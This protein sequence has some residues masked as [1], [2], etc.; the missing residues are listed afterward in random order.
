M[1]EQRRWLTADQ[2][3]E[4]FALCAFLP[5]GNIVNFCVI[6]GTRT[7][8]PL[9]AVAALGG[10]LGPPMILVM[11]VRNGLRITVLHRMLTG[12]AAAAAELMLATVAKMLRPLFKNRAV[13]GLAIA[14]ATFLAIGILHWPL[15]LVLLAIVAGERRGCLAPRMKSDSDTLLTL[16][17]FFA[18][19]SLFAI[20]VANSTIPEI[21]RFAVDVQHWLSDRQ[22]ADSFALAQITPGPNL[23]IVTLIG[24]RVGGVE[25]AIVSTLAMCAPPC[26]IAYLVGRTAERFR[27]AAWHG[28]ISRGVVPVTLG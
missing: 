11:I 5:G 2:F 16:A 10:L 21:R 12:V 9:G 1:V 26:V 14:L 24:Y 18:L 27:G 23:I 4:T 3:N 22:F 19:T 7:R 13:A 6:F 25:A 8:G 28:A 15:A 20:G 17:G